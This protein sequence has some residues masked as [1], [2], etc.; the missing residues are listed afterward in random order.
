M[1]PFRRC[2]K[3]HTNSRLATLNR[4]EL[5][6]DTRKTRKTY[7]DQLACEPLVLLDEII[8]ES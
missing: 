5:L 2:D 3:R 8:D 4:C 6:F 1:R 7:L